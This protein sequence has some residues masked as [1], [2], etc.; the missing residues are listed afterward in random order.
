M[1]AHADIDVL[2]DG[3]TPAQHGILIGNLGIQETLGGHATFTVECVALNEG[4]GSAL[5]GSQASLDKLYRLIGKNIEIVAISPDRLDPRRTLRFSGLITDARSQRQRGGGYEVILEGRSHTSLM[6]ME[7]RFRYGHAATAGLGLQ[8]WLKQA[9]EPYGDLCALEVTANPPVDYGMQFAETDFNFVSRLAERAGLWCYYDGTKLRITGQ[10]P[11]HEIELTMGETALENALDSFSL[12]SGISPGSYGLSTFN[13]DQRELLAKASGEIALA[14]DLHPWAQR[15][16]ES[17]DELSKQSHALLAENHMGSASELKGYVESLKKSWASHL[18][19]AHGSSSNSEVRI[20]VRVQLGGMA[21][22]QGAATVKYIVASISH[23][24]DVQ[25]G[26]YV[27]EF[28]AF[29]AAGA[30][31]RWQHRRPAALEMYDGQVVED[32]DAVGAGAHVAARAGQVKVRL[33][34][35]GQPGVLWARVAQ[36]YA[37]AAGGFFSMPEVGDEVVVAFLEGDPS[38]AVVVGSVY[39]KNAS[40]VFDR[41]AQLDK[42]LG[43]GFLTKG[44]NKILIQDDQGK[45]NILI[46]TPDEKNLVQLTADGGLQIRVFTKGNMS[47]VAEGN[48]DIKAGGDITVDAGGKIGVHSKDNTEI[49]ADAEGKFVAKQPLELSSGSD[50][51]IDAKGLGKFEAVSPLTL[52]SGQKVKV[53]GAGSVMDAGPGTLT[54]NS[55][56]IKLN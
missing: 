43:K 54:M 7:P 9:T 55:P 32:Q 25:Q 40:K 42:N 27:N 3:R 18:V 6:D 37:G 10:L 48:I 49:H 14:G 50:V 22:S 44:G 11:D 39:N 38:R 35:P 56:L 52:K 23:H 16:R 12:S 13:P 4:I 36:P 1:S 47:L 8:E 15:A 29:P 30:Y 17:H 21:E 51:K 45:E 41:L 34:A 26:T 24:M 28:E 20:G 46:S 53:D 31:P 33:Y 2:L 5:S 19:H